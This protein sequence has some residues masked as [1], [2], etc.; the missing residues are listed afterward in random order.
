MADVVA[1]EVA[2]A[3][4]RVDFVIRVLVRLPF[5]FGVEGSSLAACL[6]S[7]A[8]AWER[9][10]RRRR[11]WARLLRA[12][13]EEEENLEK[14]IVSRRCGV[15]D[16]TYADVK[17]RVEKYGKEGSPERATPVDKGFHNVLLGAEES[18]GTM[19]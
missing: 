18:S 8:W 14:K 4:E 5:L 7:S 17:I 13:S 9:T 1:E 12:D 16:A 2:K 6:I 11:W 3:E 10:L 15:C 19:R